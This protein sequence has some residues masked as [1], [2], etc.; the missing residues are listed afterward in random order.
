MR[1]VPQT[2]TTNR[3]RGPRHEGQPATV[4]EFDNLPDDGYR[5][6][7]HDGVL[8]VLPAPATRHERVVS[9]VHGELFGFLQQHPIGEVFGSNY[10]VQLST[11]RIYH[12]DVKFVSTF[13]ADVVR[14]KRICGVPDVVIEV[15]SPDDSDRDWRVK[16][17]AYEKAGV[18][19]YWLIDAQTVVATFY[20]HDGK[21]LVKQVSKSRRYTSAAIKGFRLDLDAMEAYVG[22]PLGDDAGN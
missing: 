10:D 22:R 21:Q 11:K 4:R 15:V 20:V 16:F 13:N 7:L 6:E 17:N 19:E 14:K 12:P 1:S 18:A 5:Y 9:Y 8:C 2:V 3:T